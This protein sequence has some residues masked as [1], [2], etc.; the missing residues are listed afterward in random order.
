MMGACVL[1]GC[2]I[3]TPPDP[4]LDAGRIEREMAAM[5]A[6]LSNH[7]EASHKNHMGFLWSIG[8]S[9]FALSLFAHCSSGDVRFNE[10]VQNMHAEL[11]RYVNE[12]ITP[13]QIPARSA[14]P[15][16]VEVPKAG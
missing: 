3:E 15:G 9:L 8:T 12:R 14:R 2:L 1:C 7:F 11:M 4:V 5:G 13:G 6:A 10:A 16:V